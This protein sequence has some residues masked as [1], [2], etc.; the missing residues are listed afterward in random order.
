MAF[1]SGNSEWNDQAN[2]PVCTSTMSSLMRDQAVARQ[3]K[4]RH[5]QVSLPSVS[6]PSVSL[7]LELPRNSR[8]KVEKRQSTRRD[9]TREMYLAQVNS[10]NEG[11][12]SVL[13]GPNT[14]VVLTAGQ[15]A[16]VAPVMAARPASQRLAQAGAVEQGYY[17]RDLFN[18]DAN[19]A[20]VTQLK[21]AAKN[22]AGMLEGQ[23]AYAPVRE[24]H[25]THR[26]DDA[27]RNRNS[28]VVVLRSISHILNSKK[29]KPQS[30][31]E[32]KQSQFAF[33]NPE[34]TD[35]QG[36]GKKK[37]LNV[38]LNK[39]CDQ[40]TPVNEVSLD[41]PQALDGQSLEDAFSGFG[42]RESLKHLL[43]NTRALWRGNALKSEAP[44][45]ASGYAALDAILPTQGWPARSIVEILTPAWGIGE[46]K[47]LLP[48][49]REVTQQKRWVIWISPPYQ[50]YAPALLQAGVDLNYVI[51]VDA[52]TS[53]KDAIWSMEKALQTPAC[54]M[55]L[56]WTNWMP[57]GLVR[58]LQLAAE[59]G[60]GMAFLFRE[61]ETKNSPAALRLQLQPHPEGVTVQVLK[62]KGSYHYKNA[63]IPL[64]G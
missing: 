34:S 36:K 4:E 51:V 15:R 22:A 31:E 5:E 18:N 35:H 42:S 19:G 39:P 29:D 43:N 2:Q 62:A 64:A 56:A 37:P 59:K 21:T 25:G 38:I 41:N 58:R 3:V 46:L 6:L 17:Q 47:L 57:N 44:S 28:R 26:S 33:T 20:V 1:K 50:P 55:V 10:V 9:N 7:P 13:L 8:F 40:N 54:A 16:N 60:G 53:C 32:S 61:R 48:K 24:K 45:H 14:A 27:Y 12:S 11:S 49:I 63:V 30:G 52:K 23:L